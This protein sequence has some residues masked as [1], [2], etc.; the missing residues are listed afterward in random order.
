M[1]GHDLRRG[2]VHRI[3]AGRTEAIDLH[4]GHAVAK[5]CDECRRAGDVAPGFTDRIDATE[6]HVVDQRG[7]ELVA[8]LYGG[9]RLTGE[10]ERGHLV[11]LSV[12]LA[13][14]ARG[15]NGI[16]DECVGH[17]S[18]PSLSRG[19]EGGELRAKRAR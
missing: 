8:I 7:I 13:A 12:D 19:G 15:T 18:S 6:H 5:S 11:Q 9:E 2:E 1:S 17:F 16:V 14:A 3:E 10:I 4:A